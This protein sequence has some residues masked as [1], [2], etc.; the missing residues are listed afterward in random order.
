MTTAVLLHDSNSCVIR[1]AQLHFELTGDL[2]GNRIIDNSGNPTRFSEFNLDDQNNF[3]KLSGYTT[4]LSF[5]SWKNYF[6]GGQKLKPYHRS[7]FQDLSISDLSGSIVFIK[8]VSNNDNVTYNSDYITNIFDEIRSHVIASKGISSMQ[9]LSSGSLIYLLNIFGGTYN[10]YELCSKM[11]KPFSWRYDG[12][13]LD[14]ITRLLA[15]RYDE[16]NTGTTAIT[17]FND[18][19]NN[20]SAGDRWDA[21]S[22][23]FANPGNETGNNF[24]KK[25]AYMA[26]SVLFTT[27]EE[28][29]KDIEFLLYFR[30]SASATNTM[31][32][33]LKPNVRTTS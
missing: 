32:N 15:I 1:F 33:F 23:L 7:K 28:S 17:A 22:A 10:L 21:V 24:K 27:K 9:H 29:I 31:T 20:P 12:L 13:D 3:T 19:D 30:C 18:I 8:D 6:Y 16:L 14:D 25:T 5:N 2:S 4:D 26:F 11:R